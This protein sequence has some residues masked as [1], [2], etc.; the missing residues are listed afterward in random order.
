[1]LANVLRFG[2]GKIRSIE[3]GSRLHEA[4]GRSAGDIAAI[5]M[6]RNR[7]SPTFVPI[8]V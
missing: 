5:E 8:E 6:D 4:R 7:G 2:D 3:F 1:M